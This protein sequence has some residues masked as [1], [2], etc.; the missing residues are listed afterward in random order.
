ML[1]SKVKVE[2]MNWKFNKKNG[3]NCYFG[4][5]YGQQKFKLEKYG[6]L[7]KAKETFTI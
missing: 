4:H 7:E 5:A 3:M 6:L 1:K 2:K